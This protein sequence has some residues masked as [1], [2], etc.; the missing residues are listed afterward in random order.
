MVDADALEIPLIEAVDT[1]F[2]LYL[3]LPAEGVQFA[4][5]GQFAHSAVRFAAIP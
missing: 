3:V 5:I 4:D 1:F 2:D